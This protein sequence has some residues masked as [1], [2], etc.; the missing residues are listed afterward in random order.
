[1][2][3][4]YSNSQTVD[5]TTGNLIN[6]GTSPTN[7][8][9]VW[10]NGVYVNQL[11][12]YAGEPGNCGPNPSITN[13]GNNINFSYGLTDLNQVIN[14]NRALAAGGTGVQLSGFNFGFSAKNGNGWDGGQQDYLAA[15]V[16][17]Y[18]S[19]GNQIANYDYSSATN[20]KYNW[21]NFNFSETFATPYVASTLS[22]AQVGFVGRDN[23]FWAGN[24]GPEIINV[25]FDLKYKVDPCATNP[26]YSSTCAGFG[27]ILNT[28]NL[29][30]STKGGSSLNQAFAINTA[31]QSAG[32]GAMVH[33]FNYGFNWR[34]GQGFS[35]CTAW[36]QDGSCSWTMNIPAYANA[37][38]S[39]TNSSNQTIHSK[40]YSFTG[41]GTSG[42]VS[43]KFL[44]PSSMNQSL[45]GTGRI[46]GSASG[47]GSSIEGAWATMI[48]TA[49]PCIANPLYSSNCK[50]YAFAIAKQLSASNNTSPVVSDGTQ[51]QDPTQPP[52]PPGSEPPPGSPPPPPGSQ[53]PPPGSEPPP[54]SQPPPGSPPPPG[55]T[56]TASSNPAGSPPANQ[57]PPQGGSSQPK[58]GEVKTAGDNKSSS[59]PVTLSSVMSMISSNQTRIGNEAK[60]VVQ[61]AESASAQSATSAQQQAETVAGS[62]VT[63]SMSSSSAGGSASSSTTARTTTQTQVSAFSLPTGQASTATSIEAI[64]PPTQ[65]TTTETIQNAGTGLSALT[66][67]YQFSSISAPST[68]AFSA[69]ESPLTN[70]GF[71]LPTGRSIIQIEPEST[72]QTEG[73]KV[74]GRS[75]LNDAIEQRPMLPNA[76]TQEQKTDAV[77]KNVQPNELAGAVDITRMATQPQGYQAYSFALADAPFYAPKEIYR[78]QVNVDNVRVLRQLSS[79]KLHQDLVNLQYK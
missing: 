66:T 8:T 9:S 51:M 40:P 44:L 58:A 6:T 18:G 17:L 79:D 65:V 75:T 55:A 28:N 14:V 10:N 78:N 36:N 70:F 76:I 71:Q 74:G 53:P 45:L 37:T 62:A 64:R 56:Q 16:K 26:A 63:Q 1:L 29:L 13:G 20:Q 11:C 73:I 61:A 67:T 22:T 52:P 68:S 72:P 38:V 30:D 54:G 50:G 32:V 15:Y 2:S 59:S 4:S 47:T 57:P 7:T 42:S 25:S 3:T 41:E 39:L 27:N 69:V 31:L 60:S 49:D 21:T 19:G 5:P 43:E 48:Y 77:N 46:V 34:V 12:F 35:G 24:Y 33:G 23:N